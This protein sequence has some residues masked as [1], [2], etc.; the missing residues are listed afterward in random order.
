MAED[1]PR[2][3]P[4]ADIGTGTG[5]GEGRGGTGRGHQ[6]DFPAVGWWPHDL[7]V[8]LD[9]ASGRLELPD[10]YGEGRPAVYPNR[11]LST[12]PYAWW[13]HE[14]L[15]GEWFRRDGAAASDIWRVFD[16]F[17]LL[18]RRVDTMVRR[19]DTMVQAVDS[20]SFRTPDDSWR[21]LAEDP[22]T[23]GLLP[24]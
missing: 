14:R 1:H 16:P 10:R 21:M 4:V 3:F 2:T 5:T 17:V 24:H 8:A 6:G 13:I 9:G 19:V 11:D 15:R 20:E 12:L 22:C 7:T 18:S 23:G